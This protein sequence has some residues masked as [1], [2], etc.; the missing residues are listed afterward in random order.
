[1]SPQLHTGQIRVT[2]GHGDMASDWGHNRYSSLVGWV[3]S[4]QGGLTSLTGW[5]CLS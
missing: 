2:E 4:S 5:L 1:M 3:T